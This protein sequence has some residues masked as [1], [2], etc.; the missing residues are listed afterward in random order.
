MRSVRNM[1]GA[2]GCVGLRAA[3]LTTGTICFGA[4]KWNDPASQSENHIR[5]RALLGLSSAG[6]DARYSAGLPGVCV[7]NA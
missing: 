6:I 3:P 2:L 4:L 7:A 1:M 5:K